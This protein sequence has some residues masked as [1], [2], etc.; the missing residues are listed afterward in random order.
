ERGGPR[1]RPPHPPLVLFQFGERRARH[2]P[3][4]NVVVREVH[5]E[6]IEPVGD[7]RAGRTASLVIGPEHEVIDEKL[8]ASAEKVLERGHAII[9]VEPV[10]LIDSN[11]RQLLAPPAT[12]SLSRVSSFSCASSA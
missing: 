8:R 6:S 2:R 9:G 10:R 11:P 3:K 5:S 7:H 1:K 4:G 12:S